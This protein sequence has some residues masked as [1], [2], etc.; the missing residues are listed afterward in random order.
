MTQC[1][2]T[3]RALSPT[4]TGLPNPTYRSDHP[5]LPLFWQPP[6]ASRVSDHPKTGSRTQARLSRHRY[7]EFSNQDHRTHRPPK[8]LLPLGPILGQAS[9][10]SPGNASGRRSDGTLTLLQHRI[11]V[12]TSLPAPHASEVQFAFRRGRGAG[13]CHRVVSP[14]IL[15]H[16]TSG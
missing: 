14:L 15:W 16:Q 11:Q 13:G 8:P 7:I 10:D 12:P 4:Y 2:H 1:T 6:R 9:A 3:R 5:G